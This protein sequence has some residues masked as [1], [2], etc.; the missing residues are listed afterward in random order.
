MVWGLLLAGMWLTAPSASAGVTPPGF[1]DTTV[2]SGL[3]FPTAVRFAP[4]GRIFVAE[5]QGLIKV[6]DNLAD[7]TPSTYADLRQKVYNASDRGLLG[8]ALDPNFATR[9]YVY[10]LYTFDAP[11]GGTA[12]V[13]RDAC[14]SP[15]GP[16]LN[17]CLASARL[18]RLSVPP[19]G[20]L[21]QETVLINDW[22]QQYMSHS[23]GTVEFGPDGALYAGAG[24]AASFSFI[25]YGQK[26][27]PPNPCGDPPVPVGGTQSLPT[28]EGGSFR[29]Q[30]LR[31]TADPATL[32]G[33]LIRVDPATGGALSSNPLAG[34]SD[35]NAR[36][37]VAYGFRNPFRFT[38]RPGTNEI[39]VGD[40]G[41]GPWEEI[42]RIVSPTDSNVEDFGWPCYDGANRNKNFEALG[43]NICTNLYAQ[44]SAATAPYFAYNHTQKV[45]AGETCPTGSSAISGLAFAPASHYPAPYGGALFFADYARNCIWAMPIGT[46][47]QPDT[48]N[49]KTFVAGAA[50]PVD[51]KVGPGGDL[52]YVDF[53]GGTI[54]RIR[55]TAGNQPPVAVATAS[56]TSGALPL[57]VNFDGTSSF[58]SDAGDTI[59]Y[60]WDLDG[61]GA[62]DDSTAPSPTHTYTQNANV[63]FRLR[64]TDSHG[65]SNTDSETIW[66][67]DTP[68]QASI[69]APLPTTTWK[70]GDVISF[71]GSATDQED[72]TTPASAFSWTVFI[73]H[74]PSNCHTH[75]LET[76]SGV[77]NGTFTAPDH[78]YPSDIVVQLT[79]TDS[80]GLS[81]TTEVVI[82][83]QTVDLRFDT[84]PSGLQLDVN[85][86][87]ATAP[88]TKTVVK[89]SV[90]T[91]TAPATQT[92]GGQTYAFSSWSDGGARSH[93]VIANATMNFTA[94]YTT[95]ATTY[96]SSILS[97]TPFL[98]WRLGETSGPFADASGHENTGTLN[99]TG[100]AR[101]QAT[102]VPG[103]PTGSVK[104]T[105]GTTTVENGAVAGLPS[106]AISAEAWFRIGAHG[107]WIDYVRHAWGGTGG[108]GW[109]L[110]SD[111]NGK[112]SWGLWQSGGPQQL[113]S[114]AGLQTNVT[115]E[116]VGT[117]DGST[118]RLYV[119]GALVASKTVGALALNTSNHRVLTGA[120]DTSAGVWIDDL[121][122]YGRALTAAQIATHYQAGAG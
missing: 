112:L 95:A 76:F 23:I 38:F 90:N 91:L 28:A 97:D 30:D 11:I 119:N 61:D 58:D 104:F 29:S 106:A 84:V 46:N 17:G 85:P 108:H 98:F 26:G 36:R 67:G 3:T 86:D 14:P 7:T 87:T 40:V 49:A 15:P 66:P 53:G 55:F 69:S 60:A 52:F 107:N 50:T 43:A 9:P 109:A 12:P 5:K 120:V 31:T 35:A 65:A 34:R 39:W 70:V 25:D 57:T 117:Y 56:P 59:S 114:Y 74:C 63:T 4:D 113:A 51:L 75:V 54:H 103:D 42:D 62:F 72:G 121:A 81:M 47:G 19:T 94:T 71:S 18:S 80:R 13:W 20:G 48:A 32:D 83:P 37:I 21:A 24:D 16:T 68:P 88:F 89:G 110:F 78:G 27:D 118:L 8:I 22:C 79:A 82:F 96:A 77:K 111:A 102:L 10:A 101:G 115:Y 99:G 1:S 2:L 41:G 105:N 116:A 100:A 92:S 93:D 33:S 64:V 45:V 122:L 6:F 73:H 44:T